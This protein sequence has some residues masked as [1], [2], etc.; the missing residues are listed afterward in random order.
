MKFKKLLL[1]LAPSITLGATIMS[2]SCTAKQETKT[3]PVINENKYVYDNTNK[4]YEAADGLKGKEL[5]DKLL[6]IQSKHFGGVGSYGGL[7]SFYKTYNAF[8][9]KYYEKDNSLLDIYSE[10]PD[11]NDPYNYPT[12]VGGNATGKE[13]GGTNREHLIPQSWF[14]KSSPMV[15]DA[16]HVFPTDI[17]VN[18]IRGNYPHGDVANSVQWTSENG[19]KLGQSASNITV[20]EPINTFKGDIAR[21]YLYFTVTYSNKALNETSQS[22]FKTVFPFIKEEFLDTYIKWNKQ[23]EVSKWDIDRNNET[24]KY[25]GGLRNPFID[26]PN[27][28][29]SIFGS[30]PKPFI[31]KGILVDIK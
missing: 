14:G 6:E 18:G 3:Q 17:K 9:D 24:A 8:K 28:D 29:E 1:L 21:A 5:L 2:V 31:N 4:Y 25:Q 22:I 20:F 23:D 15:S 26:Y 11:G 16:H 7:K 27:L 12:Y 13:G 19:S 10:N 30:D